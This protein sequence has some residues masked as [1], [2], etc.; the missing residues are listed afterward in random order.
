MLATIRNLSFLIYLTLFLIFPLLCQSQEPTEEYNPISSLQRLKLKQTGDNRLILLGE[1]HS[2]AKGIK[3][4]LT[5]LAFHEKIYFLSEGQGL[6]PNHHFLRNI[7]HCRLHAWIGLLQAFYHFTMFHNSQWLTANLSNQESAAYQFIFRFFKAAWND[8]KYFEDPELQKLMDRNPEND[9]Y[10]K[11]KEDNP[12]LDISTPSFKESIITALK[13]ILSLIQK[14][15]LYAFSDDEH[16]TILN[17]IEEQSNNDYIFFSFM[18]T[19]TTRG[20]FYNSLNNSSD[21][22]SLT[23]SL[24]PFYY[25]ITEKRDQKMAENIRSIYTEIKTNNKP[26]LVSMGNDHINRVSQILQEHSIPHIIFNLDTQEISQAAQPSHDYKHP[27][28]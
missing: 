17:W 12:E 26:V 7:D 18:W 22:D 28:M 10:R 27:E 3:S 23:N 13:D 20:W 9:I 21:P 8:I 1:N 2:K 16:Q 15:T 6:P 5:F 11:I 25:L 14:E 24:I 19:S 4:V